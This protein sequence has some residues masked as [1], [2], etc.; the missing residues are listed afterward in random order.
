VGSFKPFL[1]SPHTSSLLPPFMCLSLTHWSSSRDPTCSLLKFALPQVLS[2]YLGSG[3]IW[4]S[5]EQVV[6]TIEYT[7]AIGAKR[8]SLPMVHASLLL[9]LFDGTCPS[10]INLWEI[11]CSD[12]TEW[13]IERLGGGRIFYR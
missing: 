2:I 11:F 7:P 6:T 12:G 4:P 9:L 10:D 1:A 8:G 3:F 13:D 5:R